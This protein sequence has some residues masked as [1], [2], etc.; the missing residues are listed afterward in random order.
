MLWAYNT[1]AN[2]RMH[3]N[4]IFKALRLVLFAEATLE[5]RRRGICGLS[6]S[7]DVS[8]R[9]LNWREGEEFEVRE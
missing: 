3:S 8:I 7:V 5:M 6:I 2:M 4:Q 1:Y 9:V